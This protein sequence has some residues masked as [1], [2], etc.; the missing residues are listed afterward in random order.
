MSEIETQIRDAASRN[1][2]LLARLARTDYAAPALKQ[3]IA[4]IRELETEQQ[5]NTKKIQQLSKSREKEGKEHH[6][7][8]DS[9]VKRFA[10]KATG[11]KEK[12]SQRAEKEEREYFD[13]LR[14]ET[15]AK[16]EGDELAEQL[17][18]ERRKKAEL[19]P[20]V[21]EHV[22]A[23]KDLD[24]LYNSIFQGETPTFPEEDQQ[25][26]LT[27]EANQEYQRL[28]GIVRTEQ[29]VQQVLAQEQQAMRVCAIQIDDALSYSRVDMF[30]GGGFSDYLERSAL[31][32]A[33][34]AAAQVYRLH[35]Q[36]RKLSPHVQPLPPLAIAQGDILTDV[37]FDNIFTDYAF[38]QKIQNSAAEL[39]RAALS[40]VQ[41]QNATEE[42]LNDISSQMSSTKKELDQAR[43]E[44]QKIREGIF[45]RL[46]EQ[47]PQYSET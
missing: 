45:E 10:Y 26:N 22:K 43:K 18:A 6:K 21:A 34:Q 2:E 1:S 39:K 33:D 40:L 31:G 27:T 24:A 32:R 15:V 25:E 36:A 12:F 14:E 20:V 3:Q 23:Q 19:D 13:A 41:T 28:M 44:L 9:V 30:G 5:R 7:Y 37:F 4:F 8:A 35:E 47:L 46:S 11:K 29:Q 16:K 42:R 17:K 38:H